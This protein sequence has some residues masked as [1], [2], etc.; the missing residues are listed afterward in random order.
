MS[1][2]TARVLTAEEVKVGRL[3]R[4]A[5]DYSADYDSAEQIF[6]WLVNSGSRGRTYMVQSDMRTGEFICAC[7]HAQCRLQGHPDGRLED[8][9]SRTPYKNAQERTDYLLRYG[10]EIEHTAWNKRRVYLLPSIARN[11]AGLC[12][13]GRKVRAY[14]KRN[15]FWAPI[16]TIC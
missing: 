11:P 15:G 4:V 9:G 2:I 14:L 5:E 6:T 8:D 16:L 12:P 3:V 10:H 7:E 13:H 1:R